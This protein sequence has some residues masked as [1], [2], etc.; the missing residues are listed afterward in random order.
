MSIITE[1]GI[2]NEI[3]KLENNLTNLKIS[4]KL[5]NFQI[6]IHESI[7]LLSLISKKIK[8]SINSCA[9]NI[10]SESLF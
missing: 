2:E 4:H 7:K 1:F 10:P 3:S 9:K 6:I 8:N 5:L